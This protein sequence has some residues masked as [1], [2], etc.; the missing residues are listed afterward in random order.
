MVE[1]RFEEDAYQ[2]VVDQRFLTKH[3]GCHVIQLEAYLGGGIERGTQRVLL[4]LSPMP[5]CIALLMRYQTLPGP[6]MGFRGDSDTRFVRT[7]C[8]ASP[9]VSSAACACSQW[10]RT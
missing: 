7:D 10:M 9:A 3:P 8:V 2:L 5:D 6:A 4:R 1:Q